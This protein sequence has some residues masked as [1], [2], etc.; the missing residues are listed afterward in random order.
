[1][2]WLKDPSWGGSDG[3]IRFELFT[4][5][6]QEE[7]ME[8][9]DAE[10]NYWAATHPEESEQIR[11]NDCLSRAKPRVYETMGVLDVGWLVSTTQIRT[12]WQVVPP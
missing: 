5:R 3:E 7:A 2:T 1:V 9:N 8:W 11:T 10:H 4:E 6:W 12:A